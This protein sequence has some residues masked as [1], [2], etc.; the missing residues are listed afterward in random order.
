MSRMNRMEPQRE[1]RTYNRRKAPDFWVKFLHVSSVV[2][3]GAM[4]IIL[5]IIDRAKPEFENLFTRMFN[6]NLRQ[7]WNMDLLATAFYLCWAMLLYTMFALYV[8][9]KRHSRPGDK[10]NKSVIAMLIFSV[11]FIIIYIFKA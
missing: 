5:L 8:N 1:N 10:Y 9:S 7:D 11:G 3:W 2:V 6:I 4:L